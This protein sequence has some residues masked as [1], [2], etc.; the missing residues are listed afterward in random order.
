ME[1]T[2]GPMG[3]WTMMREYGFEITVL[4]IIVLIW[5]LAVEHD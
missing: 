4:M 2:T 1:G 5:L 3:V